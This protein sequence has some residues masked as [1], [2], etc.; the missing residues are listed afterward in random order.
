MAQQHCVWVEVLTRRTAMSGV[1]QKAKFRGDQRMSAF[2]SKA[3]ISRFMST[4]PS[5]LRRKI[6]YARSNARGSGM[7]RYLIFAALG[8]LIGGFLLLFA[9]TY[10]SG[11]WTH[12]DLSEVAKLFVVFANGAKRCASIT[13][14][15]VAR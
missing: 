10:M 11:Y 1:G 5:L 6:R 13:T 14:E 15:F 7:K 9:T 8:P 4:S 2:A 12:T 3:D